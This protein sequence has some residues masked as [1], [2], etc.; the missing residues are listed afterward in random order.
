MMSEREFKTVTALRRRLLAVPP[1]AQ[2]E[3]LLAAC[4]RF[5]TN[6]QMV[7]GAS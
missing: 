3:Q 2:I 6:E 5:G 7:G 1:H 4:Q